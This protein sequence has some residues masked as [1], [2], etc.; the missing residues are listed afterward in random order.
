MRHFVVGA[1]NFP[2][3]SQQRFIAYL[4]AQTYGWWHWIGGTWLVADSS[5]K[6][7]ASDLR[8][9]LTAVAPSARVLVME[10]KPV[11]WSGKGPAG[12]TRDMF[13]WLRKTWRS[14]PA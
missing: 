4:R 13:E 3:P 9:A 14:G 2:P 5:D 7:S 12:P 1:S 6:L 11:N 8:D 10:V